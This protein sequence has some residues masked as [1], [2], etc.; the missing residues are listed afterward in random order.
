M[1]VVLIILFSILL[2]WNISLG[3]TLQSEKDSRTRAIL[4]GM[5]VTIGILLG[6]IAAV[7]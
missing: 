7:V 1:T 3:T 6:V 5:V 4:I 2:N